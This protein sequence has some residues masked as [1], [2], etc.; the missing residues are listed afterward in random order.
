MNKVKFGLSIKRGGLKTRSPR[1]ERVGVCF[2]SHSV[3]RKLIPHAY[4]PGL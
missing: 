3:Y 1:E 4:A 2:V